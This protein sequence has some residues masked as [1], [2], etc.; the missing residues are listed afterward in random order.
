MEYAAYKKALCLKDINTKILDKTIN[1]LIE[2]K[3]EPLNI[4]RDEYELISYDYPL[5]RAT[6]WF[7][8]SSE[9]CE[10][11]D[12][13]FLSN[14]RVAAS[15]LKL[16]NAGLLAFKAKG[17][18]FIINDYN[19]EKLHENK[20]SIY[21]LIEDFY[22]FKT[23][24][25]KLI[26]NPSATLIRNRGDILGKQNG[27]AK[28]VKI[29]PRPNNEFIEYQKK[30]CATICKE[31]KVSGIYIEQ[32]KSIFYNKAVP[33]EFLIYGSYLTPIDSKYCWYNLNYKLPSLTNFNLN[34]LYRNINFKV[35][36]FLSLDKTP[37][38][39]HRVM[40]YNV[41]YLRPINSNYDAFAGLVKLIKVFKPIIIFIQCIGE[42]DVKRLAGVL[43][44]KYLLNDNV[45]AFAR[46]SCSFKKIKYGVSVN[47]INSIYLPPSKILNNM[48]QII[49]ESDFISTLNERRKI[50][51]GF[52]NSIVCGS[53]GYLG[54]NMIT[55][56]NG[57][58]EDYVFSSNTQ[59]KRVIFEPEASSHYPLIFKN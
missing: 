39:A 17:L 47:E 3:P 46:K 33:E 7:Y 42:K 55:S 53:M 38:K 4:I 41:N 28:L 23:P 54:G 30:I 24:L 52:K 59:G 9:I 19:M 22:N 27:D 35:V 51:S 36:R 49:N 15:Y 5:Y 13:L 6:N 26:N 10:S 18:I 48:H 44:C 31:F 2:E 29:L 34:P 43:K 11:K 16:Y 8:S 57:V 25:S 32:V 58:Q 1:L 37:I 20:P 40:T 50:L 56:I 21:R 45:A 12:M 14:S